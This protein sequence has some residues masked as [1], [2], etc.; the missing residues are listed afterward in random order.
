MGTAT[1]LLRRKPKN[2]NEIRTETQH[3]VPNAVRR[4]AGLAFERY[5]GND[6]IWI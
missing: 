4:G 5:G 2:R 1:T 3:T 6:G